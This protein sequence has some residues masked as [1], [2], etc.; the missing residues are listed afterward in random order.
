MHTERH[1]GAWISTPAG[2]HERSACASVTWRLSVGWGVWMRGDV[3]SDGDQ[4]E[5]TAQ[6][7]MQPAARPPTIAR[8]SVWR[9]RL[10]PTNIRLLWHVGSA[11]AP[12]I[13]VAAMLV[14]MALAYYVREGYTRVSDYAD[15]GAKFAQRAGEQ[16]LAV[17]PVGYDGQF[18]YQLAVHPRL[19]VACAQSM[20]R[21][22]L[23]DPPLRAERILYP[24]TARLL[25]LGQP[26]LVPY[27]LLAVNALAI[28]LTVVLIGRL[29]VA[30]GASPWLGAGAG[31][32]AGEILGTLRDLADPYSVMW[33]VL[34]VW[35]L[36][37]RRPLWAA[38]AA[39]AALVTR[40][41]LLFYLPFL[42]LPLLAQRR[43]ATLAGAAAIALTPFLVWQGI[44]RILYGHWALQDSLHSAPLV[45]VPFGALWQQ[46]AGPDAGLIVICVVAP[47]VGACAISLAALWRHGLR[48][49]LDDPLPLMVLA[50]CLLVSLTGNLQWYGIWEPTRLAAPGVVLGVLVAAR[51]SASLGSSFATLLAVTSLAPLVFS[52]H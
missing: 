36:F 4:L 38:G 14:L 25:A 5:L 37:R 15:I 41:Q 26:A 3:A 9:A 19:V 22:P 8:G 27:T 1:R 34:T 2:R 48:G 46:R 35:L 7:S 45:L 33:V 50:Y 28:V 18:A 21:C 12:A 52:L 11:I 42:V 20:S 23:D 51:M 24:L 31:L 6:A 29:C 32:F 47:V 16:R 13:A 43:W 17:D 40:E 30:A 49:V 39:A 10:W 44:L